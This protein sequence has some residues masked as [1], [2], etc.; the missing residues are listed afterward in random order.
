MKYYTNVSELVWILEKRNISPPY[1]EYNHG[2]PT[3]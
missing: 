1:W 3:K 2:C